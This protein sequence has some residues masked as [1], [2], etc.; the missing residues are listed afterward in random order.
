MSDIAK[1]T[2]EFV[3]FTAASKEF[4]GEFV[5]APFGIESSPALNAFTLYAVIGVLV[6]VLIRALAPRPKPRYRKRVS[7]F[8]YDFGRNH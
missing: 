5:Y 2:E 4:I 7:E 6:A 8:D 3:A 1:I